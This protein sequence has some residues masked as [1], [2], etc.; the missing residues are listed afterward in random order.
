VPDCLGLAPQHI[1]ILAAGE[2]V[3]ACGYAQPVQYICGNT[4][5]NDYGDYESDYRECGINQKRGRSNEKGL[6]VAVH[7]AVDDVAGGVAEPEVARFEDFDVRAVT[8]K[9]VS[10][11]VE[12]DAGEGQQ[13]NQPA[14]HNL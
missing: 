10:P 4:E 9:L 2:G 3:Y 5:R 12:Y 1:G 8:E 7:R 14:E 13:G 11:F 6:A